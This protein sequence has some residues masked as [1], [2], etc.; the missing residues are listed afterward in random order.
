MHNLT[1][2]YDRISFMFLYRAY[3]SDYAD[4]NYVSLVSAAGSAVIFAQNYGHRKGAK[5]QPK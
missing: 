2:K 1:S 3:I 5:G 4:V